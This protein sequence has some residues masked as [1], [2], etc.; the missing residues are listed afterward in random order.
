MTT[1]FFTLILAAG[2][3]LA[4]DVKTYMDRGIENCEKGHYDQA[5]KDFNQALKLKPND[6]SILDCLGVA[7]Y[8]KGLNDQ[9][10]KYYHQAMTLDPKYA[11]AYKNRAMVYD[12]LGDFDKAVADLKQA[13]SLGYNVDPDFIKLMEKKAAA[14]RK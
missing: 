1:I 9:A 8:A 3:A 11:K 4:Q 13:K 5:I 7:H 6:P 14:R 2:L 10:I 12:S